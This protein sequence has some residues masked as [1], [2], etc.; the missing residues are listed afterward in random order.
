MSLSGEWAFS[1]CGR[2]PCGGEYPARDT[3]GERT[4]QFGCLLPP[5]HARPGRRWIMTVPAVRRCARRC[6]V[7]DTLRAWMRDP[8]RLVAGARAGPAALRW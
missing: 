7:R 4:S 5:A 2:R 6:E 8:L 1:R 3:I